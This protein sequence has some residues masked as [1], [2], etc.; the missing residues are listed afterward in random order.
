MVIEMPNSCNLLEAKTT[1]TGTTDP[2]R[3]K[4]VTPGYEA[5]IF[6][7]PTLYGKFYSQSINKLHTL[8]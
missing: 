1:V 3:I 2:G 8:V 7:I 6:T 5:V 4:K